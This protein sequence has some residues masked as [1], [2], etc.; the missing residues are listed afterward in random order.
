MSRPK[1][2]NMLVGMLHQAAK[3]EHS[4]LDCYLYT[5]CSI[6]SLPE[7]FR[8]FEDGRPNLRRAIQFEKARQWKQSILG[9]SHEE[10]LHLHY[11]QCL[12]RALDE[13]PSFSLPD[14][15]PD[16]G[17][18]KIA[19]WDIFETGKAPEQGTEVP[20]DGLTTEQI[21][22]FILFE[23]T[24][25]L[26]DDDPFGEKSTALFQRIFDFELDFHLEGIVYNIADDA[27]RTQL[28]DALL[29]IYR[30]QPPLESAAQLKK[31]VR[32]EGIAEEDLKYVRFQSIGDFYKK[33][34]LP[35]YHQAFDK[36][37]VKNA[38]LTFNNEMQ[39]FAASEGFLPVGPV[40]RSKNYT[41]FATANSQ[42]PFRYFKNVDS[43]VNEIVEEGEGFDGFEGMV[44]TFLAK[45]VEIG[46]TREYLKAFKNDQ[47][48][49]RTKG[50][51][52]PE[53]LANAQLC[54]QSHLYRFVLIHM[55]MAFEKELCRQA[56]VTFSANRQLLSIDTNN[57][58]VAKMIA[59]MPRQFN[60]CYLGM[61][62]WL[63][64][65]YEVK[66]WQTDK[67]RR[68]AIEMIATW[69][70]M[71]LAIRPFLE[72]MTF[73]PIDLQLLFRQDK[74]SM[75]GLP[76]EATQLVDYFNSTERSESIN[77][78]IDYLVM[79]VLANAA[80]WAS[81][82]IDVIQKHSTDP[83]KDMAV[84]RLTG[85]SRL[86]EFERQFPF[87]EHGGY[88]NQMPDLT[89]Q[90]EYPDAGQYSEDPSLLDSIF[91]DAVVLKLRFG[92]FGLVQLS[93]DPDPPTDESGC[94]GTHM[95]HPADGD[96]RLDRSLVWQNLPGQKNILRSPGPKLP[97]LGVN[98]VDV[99]LEV[100]NGG[101]TAG[102]V[103]L[104]VMQSAGAVQTSGVQQVLQ[105]NGLHTL[106]RYPVSAV[107]ETPLRLNL[108]EKN[109]IR[110][111]LNGDNHLVSKD[112]EP[113]DPFIL[114]L[115]DD[116][117]Q[118][119]F[120]RE[121]FNEG[122][123]LLEMNPLERLETARWPTGFDSNLG[124]IP[125]W[126]AP[127]LP[128]GYLGRVQQGPPAYLG[129]RADVLYESLG[130]LLDG[131][132]KDT[133]QE[134][135]EVISYAERLFLVTMPRGTTVGWLAVMLHYGHS[136]SG[137][138][139]SNE[140]NNV[141][142]QF[143]EKQLGLKVS[144]LPA[145]TDRSKAN[146]RWVVKYTKG[147]M[148]TDAISDLVFGELYIP[149]QVLP[150][151]KPFV[152]TRNWVFSAGMKD[153]LGA[154]TLQFGKPFWAT[155]NV[156]G[157][158]RTITLPTGVTL[159]ETLLTA[160]GE[161]YSYAATGMPGIRNYTGRFSVSTL[162]DQ[163]VELTLQVR[164]EYDTTSAFQAM[165]SVLGGYFEAVQHS[166]NTHFASQPG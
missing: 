5:A 70:M 145:Q 13:A 39:G 103:P 92:G 128:D 71:S 112:G 88:S 164:F 28:K 26:Q 17:F 77:K 116:Q 73:F 56:G 11:V 35:L 9:V 49:A 99:S 96:R 1:E 106:I 163:G 158:T 113:V 154:Y 118:L 100:T 30:E 20:I 136:V 101:A 36:G 157:D 152:I 130:G 139:S 41:D 95:L 22:R 134:V 68:F 159:T 97:P 75:P 119:L 120:R 165:A 52:T 110:P 108:L 6:K 122:K 162:A 79:R 67:D 37:Q 86:S 123:T 63:S 80:Q 16:T 155:F 47:K 2:L 19:N 124:D 121:I 153:L 105:V 90:Q 144:C 151:G 126:L 51:S 62:M 54:R 117:H 149:L 146:S 46:G 14:R 45:V 27:K 15:N 33:G 24:D 76:T 50:Y 8:E 102:F 114:A 85:L 107:S 40:Y 55:D 48:N 72:L 111:F 78:E 31:L 91:E 81:E 59:E 34:I 89:Y 53:W 69:P 94:T 57:H 7:E 104:Q 44:E 135:D 65:I 138:L 127:A 4:L 132:V 109:G 131:G 156:S 141:L 150:D 140:D 10:M 166:L 38:N 84:T 43:V 83:L 29:K 143:L 93:T 58:A 66:L 32:A 133:Q 21:K 60:A 82:Q 148:D 25:S 74:A 147:I 87:R 142:Y 129:Q 115:T 23:S 42:N 12:L 137:E 125:A 64:R 61:V 3:L 160:D 161:S 18:W 98:L